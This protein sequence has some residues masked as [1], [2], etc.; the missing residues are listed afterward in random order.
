MAI[1]VLFV[2]SVLLAGSGAGEQGAIAD[3]AGKIIDHQRSSSRSFEILEE[4]C[5]DVGNRLAG[6]EGADRAVRWAAGVFDRFGV[7]HVR[8]QEVMVPKWV[9]GDEQLVEIVSPRRFRLDALALGGSVS[10]PEEGLTADVLAVNSFDE[11]KARGAEVEGK[12]VLFNQAMGPDGNG[13]AVGYGTA[14]SQ[15]V[16]GAIEAAR[17]GAVASIIRSVGTADFRLPHT[18]GMRYAE[19]VRK[20]PHAAIAAEDAD[21][22]MRLLARGKPVQIQMKM[23]CGDRGEVPSANVIAELKGSERPDEVVVIG[24][25]LDSWDV[26]QGAQDDGVGVAACIETIRLLDELGLRPRRTIRAVLF[27]N[28]EFGVSGG[29]AYA[30]EYAGELDGHVAAIEMDSG[31]FRFLGFGVSAGEGGVERLRFVDELL[32]PLGAEE[33]RNGGGGADISPMRPAGV[34]QIGLRSDS[35]HY[36]DYHHTEADTLDKVDPVELSKCTAGLAIMAFALAEMD[37]PLP[38]LK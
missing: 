30:K 35:T 33:I 34:P 23:N 16:K 2:A 5:D 37:E 27:M 24:C 1:T 17:L 6:S 20:I 22:I 18:G 38:R 21:L 13:G 28:E 29:K 10:T 3:A 7:Q 12:V 19:G 32:K 8:C 31:A 26:G 15:R 4:L 9:R 36:F 11:L 14:V 25:H